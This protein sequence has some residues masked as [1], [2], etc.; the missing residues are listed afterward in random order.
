MAEKR[1]DR[2]LGPNHDTF[3]EWCSKGELRLQRCGVCSHLAW[4]V[5][6]RCEACGEQ[7]FTW[8]RL[9]GRGKVVSWTTF[10]QDYY[11]GL[12]PVPY[13]TI[14]VELEE[15]ALFLS[16]PKGFAC[17]DLAPH[18]PV[19]VAFVDAEDSAGEFKLP[20]FERA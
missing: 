5:V 16:N 4:P 9:S 20:V 15:G 19:K 11:R 14:L 13:D 7:S 12:L 6:R 18:M 1:P 10:Q 8:E 3:W 17:Q 2:T